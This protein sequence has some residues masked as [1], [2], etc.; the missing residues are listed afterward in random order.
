MNKWLKTLLINLAALLLGIALS[1]AFAPYDVFPLAFLAPAGLLA[2]LL[3][4]SPKRAFWL[5][6]I[7]GIGFFGAGVYWVYISIHLYGDVPNY[8]AGLITCGL[9]AFLALFP[10]TTGYLTNR[11]FPFTT[12][13]KLVYAFPALWVTSEWVRSWLFT[14]FPWLLI[15]YSQTN[16]PLKG[17]APLLSVYGVSLAVIISSALIVNAVLGFR[18]NN[19]RATYLNLF[20]FVTIWIAGGLLDLISWTQSQGNPLS[21]SLVQGN[22]P[23]SL[24]WSPQHL[25]LSLD[26][27]AKLTEPLW[28]KDKLVIWP[29]AAVPLPLPEA[30]TFINA[31]DNKAKES[32]THL[33]LGIPIQSANKDGYYNAIVTL[34]RTRAVYLKHRLVPFGEYV[35]FSPLLFR[36]FNFMNLPLSYSIPGNPHQEPFTLGHTKIVPSICYE[37][38]FPELNKF[39]DPSVGALLTVTNDAWFGDSSAQAQHLQ[40]AEMR[41]IEFRRPVIFVSNDGITAIINP[42]GKIESSAPPHKEFVLTS[43]VQP[44]VGLTPWMRNGIDPV[45]FILICCI[46]VSLRANKMEARKHTDLQLECEMTPTR[47]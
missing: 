18:Q 34:G 32:G 40:M 20:A 26:T 22:I 25:Q 12:T 11:Y 39:S 28:G 8:L 37:I 23:Q 27:Y 42:Y 44:T 45:L 21:V 43:T 13:A 33:I 5:G 31:L 6:F 36:L 19:Y 46:A 2:L 9:I 47:Q 4:V 35:P 16:S 1:F 10:A 14:G 41:A 24:K 30:T 3:N 29:E 17:Y 15:G 7:F 38:A